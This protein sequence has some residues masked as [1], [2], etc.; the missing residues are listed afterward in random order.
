MNTIRSLHSWFRPAID[1]LF[2]P[3]LTWSIRWRLLLLQPLTTL[4]YALKTVP[5]L[6]SSAY[7]TEW[8]RPE[9][10]DRPFR[11]IIFRPKQKT[12]KLKPLHVSIHGGAFSKISLD[13]FFLTNI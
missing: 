4:T 6:F 1:A 8:I 11:V 7:R 13:Q 10:A 12:T 9:A 5:Y 3:N 2:A